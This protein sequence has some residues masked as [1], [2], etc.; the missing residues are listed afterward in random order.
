MSVLQI[1][2]VIVLALIVLA[3]FYLLIF[4]LH[5]EDGADLALGWAIIASVLYLA[6]VCA[7][8]LN[9]PFPLF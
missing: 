7:W 4:F 8:A 2:G 3:V 1:I 9:V 6:A 5:G